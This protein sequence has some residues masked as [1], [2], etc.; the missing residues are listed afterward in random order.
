[1]KT[2]YKNLYWRVNLTKNSTDKQNLTKTTL[3]MT[4]SI[5]ESRDKKN[6]IKEQIWQ[7]EQDQTLW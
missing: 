5:D 4:S 2:L 7:K 1:M 3:L 6:S